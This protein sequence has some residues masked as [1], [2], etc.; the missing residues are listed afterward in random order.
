MST[1]P[2]TLLGFGQNGPV[3]RGTSP[4]HPSVTPQTHEGSDEWGRRAKSPNNRSND[5]RTT[6]VLDLHQPSGL[7]KASSGRGGEDGCVQVAPPRQM[8]SCGQAAAA[9]QMGPRKS[10]QQSRRPTRVARGFRYTRWN[11]GLIRTSRLAG[12]R[13]RSLLAR[14]THRARPGRGWSRFGTQCCA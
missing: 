11:S 5:R 7:A 9:G 13:T 8:E 12:L 4:P 14:V 2:C 1:A 10:S 3:S 6:L